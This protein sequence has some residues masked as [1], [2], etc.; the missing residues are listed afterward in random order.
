MSYLSWAGRCIC[1]LCA[2]GCM[3]MGNSPIRPPNGMTWSDVRERYM[4]MHSQ[5]PS[6]ERDEMRSL[7][8][9][10]YARAWEQPVR[11]KRFCGV[12]VDERGEPIADV[13]LDLTRMNIIRPWSTRAYDGTSH[14]Q[15]LAN[16][17]FDV[18]FGGYSII[19]IIFSKPGYFG[20]HVGY[21]FVEDRPFEH[22]LKRAEDIL[23]RPDVLP[24]NDD[25]IGF[26]IVLRER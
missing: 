17:N 20:V 24:L 13:R 5:A 7:L 12:V 15:Q 25:P 18:R 14:T 9:L 8:R 3:T 11:A 23:L 10:Y 1:V 19:E 6:G 2:W 26:K 4:A 22:N 16:G 21:S